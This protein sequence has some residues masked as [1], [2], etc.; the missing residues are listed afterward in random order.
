MPT[1]LI[2]PF[3]IV[4]VAYLRK[5]ANNNS[6]TGMSIRFGMVQESALDLPYGSVWRRCG[7][8]VGS[9]ARRAPAVH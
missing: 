9:H 6:I 2:D 4:E 3:G 7:F 5:D 1:N 8:R